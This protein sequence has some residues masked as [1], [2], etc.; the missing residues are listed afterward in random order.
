[1]GVCVDFFTPLFKGWQLWEPMDCYLVKPVQQKTVSSQTKVI[2]AKVSAHPPPLHSL[3]SLHGAYVNATIIKQEQSTLLSQAVEALL[4]LMFF[5][6]F[7]WGFFFFLKN[8]TCKLIIWL[9]GNAKAL[10]HRFWKN[11]GLCLNSYNFWNINH[12]KALQFWG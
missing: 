1:M 9:S 12:L 5:F 7:V 8:V 2:S 3:Q 6:V 4:V 10:T 11:T